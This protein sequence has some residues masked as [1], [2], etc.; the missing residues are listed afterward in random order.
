M[1]QYEINVPE[2]ERAFPWYMCYDFETL[3]LKV[4]HRPSESLQWTQKYV[5]IS[6]FICSNVEGH[7]VPVCL[8][9]ADQ[10]QLVLSMVT[11][12]IDI[13]DSV[14]ELAKKKWGWVLRAIDDKIDKDEANDED[15]D[16]EGSSGD[17]MK[18]RRKLGKRRR[19]TLIRLRKST[20]N[21]RSTCLKS[22]CWGS[23][24]PSMI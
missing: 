9:D 6:V 4:Q 16:M 3:L 17:E 19:S 8:V 18:M 12:M 21:W 1:N 24:R 20:V 15:V 10:N 14:Y 11:R 2:A 5:P 7:T 22:T 13:A 23:T